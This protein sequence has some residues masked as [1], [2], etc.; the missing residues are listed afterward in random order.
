[1]KQALFLL[2]G[3]TFFLS[4]CWFK[5]TQPANQLYFRRLNWHITIPVVLENGTKQEFEKLK[6]TGQ[7]AI[8]KSTGRKISK[9]VNTLFH[10]KSGSTNYLNANY[11]D[12]PSQNLGNYHQVVE[13]MNAIV[14]KTMKD[15]LPNYKID[16]TLSTETIDRLTFE[17]IVIQLDNKLGTKIYTYFYMRQFGNKNLTVSMVYSDTAIGHQMLQAFRNSTFH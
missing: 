3:V 4:S 17:K 9:K 10:Y 11:E 13:K 14:Y 8:E 12:L 5:P 1:M 7:K 16:T 2:I 6:K 15:Q